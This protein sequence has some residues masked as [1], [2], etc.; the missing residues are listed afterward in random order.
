MGGPQATHTTGADLAV[1]NRG[2]QLVGKTL[3]HQKGYNNCIRSRSCG[4]T[5]RTWVQDRWMSCQGSW[6]QCRIVQL[7]ALA[8]HVATKGAVGDLLAVET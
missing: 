8:V 2:E 7:Q 1:A 4:I 6:Q 3:E 5:R